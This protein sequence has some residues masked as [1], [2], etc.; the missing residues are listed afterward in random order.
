MLKR[1]LNT[2]TLKTCHFLHWLQTRLNQALPVRN[3][4]SNRNDAVSV[5]ALALYV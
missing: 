3:D 4:L 2:S 1:V 5:A